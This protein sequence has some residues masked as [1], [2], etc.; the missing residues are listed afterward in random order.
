MEANGL[1]NSVEANGNALKGEN[2]AFSKKKIGGRKKE[3][4]KIL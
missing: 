2:Q 1:E 4:E 3:R